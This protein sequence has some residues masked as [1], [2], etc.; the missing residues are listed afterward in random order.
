MKCTVS[1]F[2]KYYKLVSEKKIQNKVAAKACNY[3]PATFTRLRKK[4]EKEGDKM[5]VH[6]L[7]GKPSNHHTLTQEQKRFIVE[8]YLIEHDAEKNPINFRYWTD[9]LNEVYGISVTY[10]PV[11]ELLTAAG[12][13]SPES[14]RPG[15][16]PVRRISFRRK[17]FGELLQ[18]DATPYQFFKWAGDYGYYTLH[19]AL[20]DSRSTFLAFYMTENECRYGYL[21]CRRQVL[22]KYGIELE[23]YSDKSP[24]FHNN[25]KEQTALTVEDQLAGTTKKPALWEVINEAL[26][27]ELHLA[28]SPQAKGKIER[29]WETVQKRLVNELRKRGIK[30]MEAANLYLE[31]EFCLYYANHF[32][33]HLD[34][35]SVFR[36]LPES[37]DLKNLL[38]VKEKRTVNNLGQISFKGLKL[39]IIGFPKTGVVVDVCINAKGLWVHYNNQDYAI[40]VKSGLHELSDV[41]QV[42][43]NIIYQYMYEEMHEHAA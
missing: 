4:F 10:K 33:K 30:T 15:R 37:L 17:N 34:N 13:E 35:L 5:F 12:I 7:K 42:L 38:C 41:P 40:E 23:D 22:V 21:E 24:V 3:D 11:Y 8:Q 43:E 31:K 26:N 6:G 19:G 20:D 16:D 9:E 29:G 1:E 28:N 32:G 18:W 36:P 39:K 2:K 14:H 25:Y 27:V